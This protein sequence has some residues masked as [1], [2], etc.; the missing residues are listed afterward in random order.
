MKFHH[1]QKVKCKII[2]IEIDDAKISIDSVGCIYICQNQIKGNFTNNKLGYE[3]S[4]H[5]GD[6]SNTEAY[7]VENL[8]PA[9]GFRPKV[10]DIV[11]D[12]LGYERKVLEVWE[13]TFLLSEWGDFDVPNRP[14]TFQQ[15]EN[16]GWKINDQEPEEIETV[17][18]I[19]RNHIQN[20]SGA[21]EIRCN[22]CGRTA[23]D[24]IE[25]KRKQKNGG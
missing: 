25:E 10:G 9:E 17:D 5:I 13:N 24:I 1:G 21:E 6:G 12:A 11:V 8:R 19:L 3:Y 23:I 15:A 14:F 16:M 4:W 18:S 22:T 2:R 20:H 7:S